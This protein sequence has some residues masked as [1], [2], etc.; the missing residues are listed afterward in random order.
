MEVDA[1]HHNKDPH[2]TKLENPT[3]RQ[4]AAGHLLIV[5]LAY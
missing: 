3:L 1:I 4:A 5:S 2:Q